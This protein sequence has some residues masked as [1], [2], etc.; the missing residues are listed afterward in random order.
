MDGRTITVEKSKSKQH[1]DQLGYTVHVSNLS[2]KL[3]DEAELR[4]LFETKYGEVKRAHLVKD[5]VTGRTKGFA[6]VEF[7]DRD[8]MQR[9]VHEK[10]VM[11]RDRL[12]IIK[13][14]TR[15]ITAEIKEK[16]QTSKK[17]EKKGDRKSKIASIL[18]EV[19]GEDLTQ[20]RIAPLNDHDVKTIPEPPTEIAPKKE[21]KA[22]KIETSK[23]E[24]PGLMSNSD[25]K[26][27]LFS[28]K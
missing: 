5:E 22:E 16:E 19:I 24:Q 25:F 4:S 17:R 11:I 8:A 6:F 3:H 12:A 15:Q 26:K 2:F 7:I 14:S 10:E 21:D 23:P 27:L 20:V 28:R 13:K 9:A 1:V 18:D